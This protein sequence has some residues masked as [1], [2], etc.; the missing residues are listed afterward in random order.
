VTWA[1]GPS[2]GYVTAILPPRIARF[3]VK[4]TF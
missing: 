1:S 3:G 2:Y 4:F